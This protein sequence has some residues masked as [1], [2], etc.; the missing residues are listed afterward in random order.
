MNTR[1][2]ML[3][4]A[5]AAAATLLAGCA[6]T[7]SSSAENGDSTPT[8]S[9]T[10]TSQA[11]E[12]GF[13]LWLANKLGY[14]KENHLDVQI[15]YAANGAAA[16]A[17]GSAGDWQAGW[18]GG[19]PA[20]TGYDTWGLIPVGSQLEEAQNLRLFIRADALK[21][22]SAKKVLESQKVATVANSTSSQ[23]LYACA[24]KL[25]V[26]NSK[27]SIIPLDPP[28]IVSAI[29]SGQ[30]AAG[31]AF[32]SPNYPL[33]KDSK[34]YVQV[35]NG[36]EAGISIVDPYIV[37]PKFAKENPKAAARYI[38]AVYK[39]NEYIVAHPAK[40]LDEMVEFYS[41]AGITGGKDQAKVAIADRQWLTLDQALK[42]MENGATEKSLTATAQFFVDSGAYKKMPDVEGAIAE[43]LKILKAADALRK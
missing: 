41:A 6:S 37:T 30:V 8:T 20:L 38:N 36:K 18:T 15:Q 19:P 39:A 16:L 43:G 3:P 14:F 17:S 29:E 25:G 26:D 27:M 22:S 7:P 32:S 4:V 23:A 42:Q 33:Q 21:G 40:V 12:T 34:E 11:N 31:V 9:I 28:S 2:L 1:R 24:A 13:T 35:C 10:L 5:I